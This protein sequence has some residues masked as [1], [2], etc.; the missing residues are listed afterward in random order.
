M[1]IS[2]PF[3]SNSAFFDT[4]VKKICKKFVTNIFGVILVQ[5]L[6]QTY[7]PHVLKNAQKSKKVMFKMCLRIQFYIHPWVHTFNFFKKTK[8]L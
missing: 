4:H 6:L 1:L 7:K 8:L 3:T 5:Y 2:F